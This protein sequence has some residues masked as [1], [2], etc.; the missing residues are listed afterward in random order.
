[1]TDTIKPMPYGQS[2]IID[3]NA[4]LSE[5][6]HV[7]NAWNKLSNDEIRSLPDNLSEALG[8]LH[9]AVLCP[10]GILLNLTTDKTPLS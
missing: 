6:I 8:F 9:D 4:V 2:P 7:V 3:P 5:S 1:M 10:D